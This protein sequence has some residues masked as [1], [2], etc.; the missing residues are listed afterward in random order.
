MTPD[1][2]QQRLR[3]QRDLFNEEHSTRL[4]RANSWWRAALEQKDN[5][6]L[7]FIT[8]WVSLSCCSLTRDQQITEVDFLQ[9]IHRLISLDSQQQVYDVIWH[10]YSGPVKALIKNPYVYRQFWQAQRDADRLF[11]HD[12]KAGFERS[13]VEA[14]NCLSR[15]KVEDLLVITL[16]RLTV[17]REQVMGGGATYQGSVN[18]EQVT[19]GAQLLMAL[20]PVILQIMLEHPEEDW[21]PLAY[22]V[23]SAAMV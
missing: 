4:H 6:D 22:P 14:L 18:R 7:Q 20:I 9:L 3:D 23:T 13:S 5:P 10:R 16:D 8:A 1:E 2:F 12:W 11:G 21:G 15:R 17:L 19:T